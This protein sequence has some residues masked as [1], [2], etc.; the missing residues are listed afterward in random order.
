M[1]PW[2]DLFARR[3]RLPPSLSLILSTIY[4]SV[5]AGTSSLGDYLRSPAGQDVAASTVLVIGALAGAA[6]SLANVFKAAKKEFD[7][8]AISG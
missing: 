2:S 5:S 4:Q 6:S 7:D 1:L 3:L 8:N